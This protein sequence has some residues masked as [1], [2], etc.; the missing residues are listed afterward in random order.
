MNQH[1]IKMPQGLITNLTFKVIIFISS[2]AKHIFFIENSLEKNF[3][4]MNHFMKLYYSLETSDLW[5]RLM[6]I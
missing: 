2:L 4:G 6:N 1:L 5:H 3:F